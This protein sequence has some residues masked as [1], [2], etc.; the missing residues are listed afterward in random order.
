MSDMQ[1]DASI[2]ALSDT[3]IPRAEAGEQ[4]WMYSQRAQAD[5]DADGQ[6]ET[7]V[8]LS[9]VTLNN[10]GAPLWE[11]GH[12]WQVYI[13]EP[14]GERTY[15]YRKFLPRGKLTAEVVRRESGTRT[16]LLIAQTPD[17]I[18]IFEVKYSGPQRIVLMNGLER[19][20]ESGGTFSGSPRP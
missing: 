20:V 1:P 12:R 9:D 17:H 2:G 14:T 11:D 19:P 16:L 15:I 13:E 3:A 4:G 10:G 18:G 5:F 6:I 8:L 7:A